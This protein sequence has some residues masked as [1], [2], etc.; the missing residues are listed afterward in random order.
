MHFYLAKSNEIPQNCYC[1]SMVRDYAKFR[2]DTY[3]FDG[4]VTSSIFDVKSNNVWRH[5]SIISDVIDLIY[6]TS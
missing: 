2:S 5:N 4:G 6:M 3:I 1:Y